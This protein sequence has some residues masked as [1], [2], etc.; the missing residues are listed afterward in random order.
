MKFFG[1]F[2]NREI[3]ENLGISERTVERQWAYAR[4]SLFRMIQDGG[5][6]ESA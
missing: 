1:G 6:R 3:A 2:T 5:S 4:N